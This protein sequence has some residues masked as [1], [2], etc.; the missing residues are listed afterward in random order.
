MEMTSRQR[1]MAEA[2]VRLIGE[3]GIARTTI[4]AIA[5][6]VGLTEAAFYRH[7]DSKAEVLTAALEYLKER[8]A[9]WMRSSAHPWVPTRLR[10]IGEA[11]VSIL[12]SD[13]EMY[14][15][16]IMHFMLEDSARAGVLTAWPSEPVAPNLR[17]YLEEGK[18][19]GSIHEDLDI[20]AFAWQWM[21]WAMGE[22]LHFLV[23]RGRTA[24]NRL[25]HLRVLELMIS[26]AETKP[27]EA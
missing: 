21:S 23:T 8:G 24:F 18:A 3:R 4:S 14:S 27:G 5:G 10:E 13:V 2:A 11:H 12:S 17:S 9:E 1:Q 20:E 7:F 15:L 19:Q 22:D 26:D 6:A 16:P 25:H